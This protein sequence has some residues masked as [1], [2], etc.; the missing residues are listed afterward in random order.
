MPSFTVERG[1][2]APVTTNDNITLDANT[3]GDVMKVTAVGLGGM[4][5]TSTGYRTRWTRPTTAGSGIF[6][7]LT[8]GDHS[9]GYATP[10]GRA[11][12][13][14][15]A[16]TLA[17]DPAGN[18]LALA[19][20]AHGGLAYIALPLASPWMIVNGLAQAQISC[21]NTDGTNSNGSNY[22]MTWEE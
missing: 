15:T 17:G 18:L 10:L 1:A 5:T 20:N 8:E 2:F 7:A 21:R 22:H 19:W 4:L 11:G 14:A 6:T 9:P 16:P 12:T 13:F 3:A